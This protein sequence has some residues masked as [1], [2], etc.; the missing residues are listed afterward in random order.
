MQRIDRTDD[1]QPDDQQTNDQQKI[2]KPAAFAW[3]QKPQMAIAASFLGAM[4]MAY[5]ASSLFEVT[6]TDES[7]DNKLQEVLNIPD[8]GPI[9]IKVSFANSISNDEAQRI[10]TAIDDRLIVNGNRPDYTVN[11]PADYDPIKANELIKT[12]NSKNMI[13]NVNI[14]RENK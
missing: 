5:W 11:L 3:Y 9:D 4:L 6:Y 1:T 7:G 8:P 14:V 13:T 10:I 2:R 12:L